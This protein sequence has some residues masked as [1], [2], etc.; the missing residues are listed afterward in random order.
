MLE[1]PTCRSAATEK[2]VLRPVL[3]RKAITARYRKYRA[4]LFTCPSV[5]PSVHRCVSERRASVRTCKKQ[6]KKEKKSNQQQ[7]ETQQS[8]SANFR[9]AVNEGRGGLCV[10]QGQSGDHPT[11]ANP[12]ATALCVSAD[13]IHQRSSTPTSKKGRGPW[14]ASM[15]S[16]KIMEN[17][18]ITIPAPTAHTVPKN[19][20]M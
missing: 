7:R 9:T 13:E 16:P 20:K 1:A 8:I 4:F 5:R 15:M 3:S 14:K 11:K 12:D 18:G 2:N 17:T 19:I 6:K 10:M